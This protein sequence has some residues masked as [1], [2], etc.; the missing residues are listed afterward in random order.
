MIF[1]SA[2]R[3]RESRVGRSHNPSSHWKTA[4]GR[5]HSRMIFDASWHDFDPSRGVLCSGGGGIVVQCHVPSPTCSMIF[6]FW[7][8]FRY[9]SSP[10]PTDW[11]S[12]KFMS[13]YI[14]NHPVILVLRANVFPY[15][16]LSYDL[17][18]S[19]ELDVRELQNRSKIRGWKLESMSGVIGSPS[20]SS[21]ALNSSGWSRSRSAITLFVLAARLWC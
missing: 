14:K 18:R 9:P 7:S 4:F 19:S 8:E 16:Y 5:Y 1:G 3:E 20:A 17:V 21:G 2:E 13:R 6:W 15:N 10:E 12:T 11:K